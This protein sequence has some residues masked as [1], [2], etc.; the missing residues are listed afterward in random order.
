MSRFKKAVVG[1]L[2]RD[3]SILLVRRSRALSQHAGEI[4]LPG[5]MMKANESKISALHRELKE[6]LGLDPEKYKVVG[7][8]K[9]VVTAF[10][11]IRIFPFVALLSYSAKIVPSEEIESFSF[12]PLTSL[13]TLIYSD[14]VETE[15][16]TLWGAT[17]RIIRNLFLEGRNFLPELSDLIPNL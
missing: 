6:E 16:G 3:S 15:L 8:L 7:E 12:V 17:A 13:R 1:I 14:R 5:G 9:D 10:T 4:G 11:R 2:I